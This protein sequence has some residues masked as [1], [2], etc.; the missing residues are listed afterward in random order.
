MSS[1]S[2]TV[3]NGQPSHSLWSTVAPYVVPP[4][5]AAAA[6]VPVFQDLIAKSALQ[7][8]ESVPAISVIEGVRKGFK[9]APTVGA[10]VGTQMILQ[11][12]VEK[13]LVKDEAD[14]SSLPSKLASS[15]VVGTISAPILAVFNGQTMGWS[16][17]ESLRRFSAKQGLAIAL[18]ETA[19]VGGLSAADLL[20][21]EM[22][23]KFGD[24]KVVECT[25]AFTA[26]AAGSLAGHPANTS[27]TRWQNGLTVDSLRQSM[28]GAARK[29][30]AAGCF[31]IFYKFG[32]DALNDS[33]GSSK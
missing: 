33:V 18:Q 1:T 2:N 8:G 13:T 3:Q 5:A 30:R 9:A 21:T 10:I 27:L 17:R 6:I 28:W 32:K 26:G 24:N 22:K 19:F 7:K 23:Q 16:L 25:A 29:A 31:S 15:A 11:S 20:A 14:K 12:F 4:V